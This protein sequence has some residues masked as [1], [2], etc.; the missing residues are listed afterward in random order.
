[1]ETASTGIALLFSKL[2]PYVFAL[3]LSLWTLGYGEHEKKK[4]EQLA[5]A[6][7]DPGSPAAVAADAER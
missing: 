3:G 7:G 5:A 6:A 1:V 4:A 2:V